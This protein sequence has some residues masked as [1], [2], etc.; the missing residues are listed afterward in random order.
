M[1]IFKKSTFKIVFSL[2]NK[3]RI[4]IDEWCPYDCLSRQ[5]DGKVGYVCDLL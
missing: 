2:S 1:K 4:A 5:N 3:L